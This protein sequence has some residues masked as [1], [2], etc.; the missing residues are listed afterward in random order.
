MPLDLL[1][2]RPKE[3]SDDDMNYSTYAKDLQEKLEIIHNFATQRIYKSSDLMKKCQSNFLREAGASL[4]DLRRQ[5]NSVQMANISWSNTVHMVLNAR[6]AKRYSKRE[7][8][9]PRHGACEAGDANQVLINKQTGETGLKIRDEYIQFKD[10]HVQRNIEM[11]SRKVGTPPQRKIRPFVS[12]SR[13]RSP[14]RSLERRDTHRRH[15]R[16]PSR[17]RRE[18]PGPSVRSVVTK[19]DAPTSTGRASSSSPGRDGHDT[20]IVLSQ[21]PRAVV[22]TSQANAAVT[23]RA[24]SVSSSSSSSSSSTSSDSSELSIHA[25][26]GGVSPPAEVQGLVPSEPIQFVT[27]DMKKK[28]QQ[29]RRSQDNK[30][31][32][33]IWGTKFETSRDTL[34]ILVVPGSLFS[35]LCQETLQKGSVFLDRDPTHFKIVLNYLRIRDNFSRNIL[36]KNRPYL[37]EM[38]LEAD[39]Y[40]LIGLYRE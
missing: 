16:S 40:Q 3:D 5:R 25:E 27:E 38:M 6:C 2:G 9:D 19:L 34:S 8:Q 20:R 37:E 12:A 18:E 33:N 32:M 22:A 21:S 29:V 23:V 30:I 39:F 36:P 7:Q 11:V 13:G 14:K 24:R 31:I 4:Q 17:R 28:M 35:A 26:E 10:E 1:I 15:S